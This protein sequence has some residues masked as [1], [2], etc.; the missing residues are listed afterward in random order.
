MRAP[1]TCLGFVLVALALPVSAEWAEP[2]PHDGAILRVSAVEGVLVAG[3][4]FAMT[5]RRRMMAGDALLAD[6]GPDLA[7]IDHEVDAPTPTTTR[8]PSRCVP[9]RAM[10]ASRRAG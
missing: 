8:M 6:G 1:F 9:V 4:A 2:V 5:Q 7:A 3:F 10:T